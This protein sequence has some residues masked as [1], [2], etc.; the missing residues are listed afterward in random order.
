LVNPIA[1]LRNCNR[2]LEFRMDQRRAVCEW[3]PSGM[4]CAKIDVSGALLILHTQGTCTDD[5]Q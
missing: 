3:N 2:L 4:A 1:P 5:R